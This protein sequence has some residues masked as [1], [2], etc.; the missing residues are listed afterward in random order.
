MEENVGLTMHVQ[1]RDPLGRFAK[2]IEEGATDAADDIAKEGARLS[3]KYAPKGRTRRLAGAIFAVKGV[4]GQARWAVEG[5][6][7]LLT[8]AA[9]QEGGSRPHIIESHDG[10]PLANKARP[11]VNG[12]KGF[13]AKSGRVRHPGTDA[14]HF[15]RRA[16]QEMAARAVV[17]TKRR[18]PKG[19]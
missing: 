7:K 11:G 10:G 15:M 5:G 18:M 6:D 13:Y 4:R 3:A 12:R 9:S 14:I 1:W 17:M 2:Q 8:I 16:R 19:R